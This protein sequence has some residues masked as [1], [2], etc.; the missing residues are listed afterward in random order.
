MKRWFDVL[1]SVALV[2]AWAVVASTASDATVRDDAPPR[3]E[4]RA[5]APSSMG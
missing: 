3:G 5:T 4:V 2:G 1:L